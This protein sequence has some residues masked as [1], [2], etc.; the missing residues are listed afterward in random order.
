MGG[1]CAGLYNVSL[2]MGQP[3]SLPFSLLGT[4]GFFGLPCKE[5]GIAL[6]PLPLGFSVKW[7]VACGHI[8][9]KKR[10][11]NQRLGA[12]VCYTGG[13]C[14]CPVPP[15]NRHSDWMARTQLVLQVGLA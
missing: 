11:G 4:V 9:F 14:W 6:K 8:V 10:C 15:S 2:E 13:G 3:D 1:S 7:G 5:K 12:L